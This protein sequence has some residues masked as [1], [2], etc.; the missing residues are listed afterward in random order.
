[1]KKPLT[2]YKA[3]AGS[4]KTYT[5]AVEYIK[6][7]I[8]N[9]QS[10]S[11]ILA[12]TFT[13][14]ATEEM[15]MRILSQLYGIWKRLPDSDSYLK[16]I[17]RELDV[18]EEYA[19]EQ[20]GIAL[21]YLIHN[22]NYFRVETIDSFFQNVLRNLA[23]ELDLTANLRVSLNDL[24][25]EQEA[26]NTLIEELRYDSKI[27]SWIMSLIREKMDENKS[28]NILGEITDFGR[29]IFKDVYKT[30]FVELNK[31]LTDEKRFNRLVEIIKGAKES[32]KKGYGS[33]RILY[34]A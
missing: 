1:M 23:R 2:V 14:K 19:S 4:G 10:Y 15:K 3:S 21:T 5:L 26:V 22:Y 34:Q 32:A 24:Q 11:N 28:W 27:L 20:A 6:L 30:H 8:K 29:N 31:L 16:K 9:P 17:T 33:V 12:V 13:N 25:V 7:L 18:S